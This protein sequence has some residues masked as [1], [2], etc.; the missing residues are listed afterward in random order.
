MR[1]VL[2]D[3]R[4]WGAAMVTTGS[5]LA[6]IAGLD[7]LRDGGNAFDAAVTVSAV[8]TVAMPMA[9][10]PGGDGVA[11]LHRA[12]SAD[13]V[14]L[15]ALG[16]APSGAS[17]EAY[18]GR[19]LKTVPETGI[20][21]VSTPGLMDGWLAVYREFGSLPMSRL[22]A[23][24]IDFAERG[25][26]VTE[27]FHRWTKDN[28]E[29]VE[30]TQLR[31][32]YEPAA[33]E[34]AVGS[35]L[36]QPGL[37][38]LYAL[39]AKHADEPA[40][41]RVLLAEA[42]ADVSDRL[43]GFVTRDDC[44]RD[45]ASLNSALT[46]RFAGH[47]VA[48]TA[49]PTQGPLL[50]QNLA[51]YERLAA[52]HRSDSPTGM[53]VLAEIANQTYGWRLRHLGDP[54]FMKLP[55]PLSEPVLSE[56]AAGV[57]PRRRGASVCAGHYHQG[58]TTHFAVLDAEGNGVSWVQSLGLAFGSGAGVPELG[59][60]L[61]DRLGRSSTLGPGEPNRTA[62]GK[63]P[64]NTILPWSI[65]GPGGLR[66]LGGTP[67]GDGQTQ[68]NAQTVLAL[69]HDGDTSLQALS[70]PQWTYYP[71]CDKV[72]ADVEP[73]LRIDDAMPGKVVEALADRGHPV[74]V[75]ASV[76]GVKRL[77]ER[78]NGFACGLDDGRQEG[79]TA[80]W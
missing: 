54:D 64:V 74:V 72:E 35:A 31:T 69:L 47:T 3:R 73:H 68:W 60:F 79:L 6:T 67:G 44:L 46:L 49:A 28:L 5:S 66:W 42:I 10:G 41:L 61:G 37:A 53:H 38:A 56:L 63:R 12:G 71:G 77:V 23:P 70:R 80:S 16:R 29:S 15:T 4:Q 24:A 22:L 65:S 9:C 59:L 18:A 11:V 17:V 14:A 13:A 2:R 30:D 51:L 26:P 55:N 19:G 32:R 50:L 20:L 78:G 25:V 33:A 7:V 76:G 39:I 58:D 34:G 43:D 52:E 57:D 21:S 8:M 1:V 36:R 45:N 75:K 62:P 48:T 27:Q 40:A